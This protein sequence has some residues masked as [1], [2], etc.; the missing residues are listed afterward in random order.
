MNQWK[1]SNSEVSELR[2]HWTYWFKIWCARL[3]WQF[4]LILP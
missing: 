4:H 3:C 1:K 2:N